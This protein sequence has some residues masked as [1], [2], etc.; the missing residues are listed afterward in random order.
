MKKILAIPAVLF[1]SFLVFTP[2]ARADWGFQIG[3]GLGHGRISGGY[4]HGARHVHHAPIH[5]APVHVHVR[6][7]VYTSVWVPPV[8][9]QAIVGYT[10]HG[11][12]IHGTVVV[13]AGYHKNVITGYRCSSCR[14][15][16]H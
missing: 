16:C 15:M 11:R 10:A 13:R 6:V 12:P 7:P 14:A 4:Y 2:S 3:I 9:G 1:L 8:Y 5:V